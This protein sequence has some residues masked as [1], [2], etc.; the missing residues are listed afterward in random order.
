VHD[1]LITWYSLSWLRHSPT[2]SEPDMHLRGHRTPVFKP[3]ESLKTHFNIM[4]LSTSM[5]LKWFLTF[6]FSNKNLS[7]P[8]L[9]DR[10]N[11]V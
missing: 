7:H 11:A 1:F 2:F 3:I 5:S 4:L 8:S 10:S 9:F 6:R